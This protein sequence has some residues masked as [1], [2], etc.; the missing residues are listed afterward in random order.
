MT[1]LR[2]IPSAAA[3]CRTV[4][5]RMRWRMMPT[6]APG[7]FVHFVDPLTGIAVAQL[8]LNSF[9]LNVVRDLDTTSGLQLPVTAVSSGE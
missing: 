6:L 4:S 9:G 5:P 1:V 8:W 2:A 7:L 3:I